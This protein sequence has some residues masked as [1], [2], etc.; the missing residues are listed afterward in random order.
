MPVPA[1]ME[2]VTSAEDLPL[3]SRAYRSWER[4]R[5]ARQSVFP[6]LDPLTPPRPTSNTFL[7]PLAR[8][9]RPPSSSFGDSNSSAPTV[10]PT[11]LSN[12]GDFT[13]SVHQSKVLYPGEAFNFILHIAD[14][15]SPI[16][17]AVNLSF[18]A[19]AISRLVAEDGEETTTHHTL[20][21]WS[22]DVPLTAQS[23][24][25]S[26]D[27]P[28]SVVVPVRTQCE[29]CAARCETMPPSLHVK[30]HQGALVARVSYELV[31]IWGEKAAVAEVKVAQ[32]REAVERAVQRGKWVKL[33]GET[34]MR[35]GWQGWD[36]ERMEVSCML[37][38][39]GDIAAEPLIPTD[40][41][42]AS[43]QHVSRIQHPF[44]PTSGSPTVNCLLRFLRP[45]LAPPQPPPSPFRRAFSPDPLRADLWRLGAHAHQPGMEFDDRAVRLGC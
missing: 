29:T 33:D 37:V 25:T 39:R 27:L 19:Q 15:S 5:R 6:G 38:V 30:D 31:A 21:T 44:S 18:S 34:D 7:A 42:P 9:P 23:D 40:G 3:R 14:Y 41:L 36:L 20:F 45:L 32:R 2:D 8:S 12:S 24:G 28:F 35:G 22:S 1:T 17:A 4:R 10:H 16:P 11:A 13:L 26:L 43:D